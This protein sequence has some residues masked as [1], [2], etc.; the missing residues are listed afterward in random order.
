MDVVH[1]SAA[2]VTVEF[3][4]TILRYNNIVEGSFLANNNT[5]FV[6][7]G[8]VPKPPPP[9]VPNKITVDQ[10]IFGGRSVSGSGILFTIIFTALRTGLSP[11]AIG[12]IDVR[13]GSNSSIL[14]QVVS[15]KVIVNNPP[16]AARLLSPP[17]GSTIDTSSRV[18]LRWLKSIDS[19]SGDM[20]RYEVHLISS[21]SSLK[22]GNLTDTTFTL[23]E[24]ALKEDTEYAWYVDTTDGRDTISSGQP[25]KFKT[26][27]IRYHAGLPD[28]FKVEQNYPNPFNQSTVIRFS[29]PIPVQI[30]VTVY[31]MNGREI[32]RL[33]SANVEPGY[34][35]VTWDGKSSNGIPAGSGIYLYV[36][37][38]GEYQQAG[39][40]VLLR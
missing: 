29:V 22:F 25:F 33:M 34:Y 14:T 12:A 9:A 7:L 8:I 30:D 39:K 1:L 36:V 15:G 38:A 27:K 24:D 20:V 4:N 31:D 18:T 11:V 6:F 37:S 26:P 17:N 19:D 28:V 10:A 21:L 5:N 16:R 35:S 32:I 40:M 2:S 3:D 23:S 13:N